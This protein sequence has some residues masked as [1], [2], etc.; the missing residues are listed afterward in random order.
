MLERL[1]DYDDHLME[2]LITEIEPPRD[3]VFDDLA[4]ELQAGRW[5]RCSSAPPRAARA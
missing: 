3:E 2:E 1:A 5:F 4:K